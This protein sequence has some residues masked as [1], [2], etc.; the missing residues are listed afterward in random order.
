MTLFL[1]KIMTVAMVEDPQISE[2][3][4]RPRRKR[5]I[6]ITTSTALVALI[7]LQLRTVGGLQNNSFHA[8]HIGMSLRQESLLLKAGTR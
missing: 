7:W 6:W 1:R 4:L 8:S 3:L 2:I 5:T